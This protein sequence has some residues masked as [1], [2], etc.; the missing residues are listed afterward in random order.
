M[1]KTSNIIRLARVALVAG[2]VALQLPSASAVLTSYS[3][4]DIF[5]GFRQ[6]AAS[7]TLA[8]NL[9]SLSKFLTPTYGGTATPGASFNVTFGVIPNTSTVVTNLNA[10]LTAVFGAGW[11]TNSTNGTSVRWSVSGLTDNSLNN[12]PISGYNAR[13]IL[14]TK[15]RTNPAVQSA[16]LGSVIQDNFAG[17]FD[18][19]ANSNLG[20]GFVGQTSTV[21]SSVAFIGAKTDTNNYNTRLGTN[22]SFGLGATRRIEQLTSGANQGPTNSVLDFYLAPTSGSTLATSNTYLGNFSLNSSGELSFTAVPEPS[23]YALLALSGTAFMVFLR[24]RKRQAT[25]S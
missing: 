22:G 8:V 5:I 25:L 1:K 18:S 11:A 23:T 17:E 20:G 7:N 16:V 3:A 9:G 12:T 13:T 19:F 21:N 15:A 10:D 24:R 14:V 4:G 2:A 6:T